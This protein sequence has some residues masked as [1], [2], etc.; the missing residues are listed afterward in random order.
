MKKIM[1]F[2]M[3]MVLMQTGCVLRSVPE[4][5]TGA[6]ADGSLITTNAAGKKVMRVRVLSYNIHHGQ[7][8]DGR[9]VYQ[10]FVDQILRYQPHLV[11]MQE[12]DD[13]T[14]RSK[15]VKQIKVLGE[16]TGMSWFF[17]RAMRFSGGGY[18]QGT[19]SRLKVMGSKNVALTGARGTE[20]RGIFGVEVDSARRFTFFN[21]HLSHESE[22]SRVL[23]VKQINEMVGGKNDLMLMVG[24]FNSESDG[25]AYDLLIQE[26]EDM[27]LKGGA[28]GSTYP[29]DKPNVRIDYIFARPYGKWRVIEAK[30]LDDGMASD[31]RGIFA[32]L[33]CDVP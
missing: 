31:H 11:A 22:K 10:R 21:V 29:S 15:G 6:S 30:V 20:R 32:V 1:I 33:E 4:N 19:L 28:V 18:G 5:Q 27:M 17:G 8:M 25:R 7:G 9:V 2:L 13:A 24:D 23:Q 16:L 26:W 12:V 14:R 3:A